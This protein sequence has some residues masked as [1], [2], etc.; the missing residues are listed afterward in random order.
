MTAT[1]LSARRDP[2]AIMTALMA[3]TIVCIGVITTSCEAFA[4]FAPSA[5]AARYHHQRGGTSTTGSS[6]LHSTTEK[7]AGAASSVKQ[8]EEEEEEED[9]I[10]SS[11]PWSDLQSW[12]LRDNLPR[13]VITI[14]IPG[15]SRNS[16]GN[17]NSNSDKP[18]YGTY[19]LW[20][21]MLKETTELS[22]YEVD[23]V[24]RA[25]ERDVAKRED[26]EGYAIGS[27]GT[28]SSKT[29]PGVL[30]LLESFEFHPDGG[31]SGLA[32]GIPGI[33]GGSSIRT[34]AVSNMEK[35][36]ILGYI[37]TEDGSA[38]YELGA[39]TGDFYAP[40]GSSSGGG[41]G[42]G[43]VMSEDARRTMLESVARAAGTIVQTGTAGASTAGKLAADAANSAAAGGEMDPNLV[44]LA[45][46]TAIV[47]AGATA[48]G[49]MSHHLTVNVFWV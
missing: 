18:K 42:G 1:R 43:G 29:A 4:P 17:S 34:T 25:Y 12:A 35:T 15:S 22:G 37:E 8:E 33:A 49:M 46:T 6:V 39:P 2:L 40:L 45:G 7:Q 36:V 11:M 16:N 3:V 20:R 30:P 27:K 14:P 47:L 41:G 38:A 31:V 32:Y 44:N 13:Y 5:A 28:E 21:T 24:R 9:E 48:I 10:L 26:W 23:Y 19:A